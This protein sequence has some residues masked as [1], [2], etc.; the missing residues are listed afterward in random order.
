MFRSLWSAFARRSRGKRM[1]GFLLLE[2]LLGLIS[3]MIFAG[4]LA[5]RSAV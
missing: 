4:V 3:Q 1:E 5:G 2:E